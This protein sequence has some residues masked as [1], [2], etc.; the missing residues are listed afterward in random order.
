MAFLGWE[1]EFYVNIRNLLTASGRAKVGKGQGG[2]LFRVTEDVAIAGDAVPE[3]ADLKA[4]E[5][6]VADIADELIKERQLYDPMLATIAGDWGLLNG[7]NS[8]AVVKTAAQGR[9]YTGGKWTRPDLCSIS[10][11][12]YPLV[13]G[14]F[15]EVRTFEV[16]PSNAINVEAVYEALAHRRAATHSY[17]LLHIPDVDQESFPA[18][19]D[20]DRVVST[21]RT[22]GIGVIVAKDPEN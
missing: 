22:Y 5:A 2:S 6:E 9:R 21:A 19:D 10:V 20:L 17:V 14:R 12:T 1:K 13:P 8:I 4:V 7:Y 3:K 11:R 15:L 18:K 16:K